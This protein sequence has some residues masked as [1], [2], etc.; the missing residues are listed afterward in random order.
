ML[1]EEPVI[2]RITLHTTLGKSYGPFGG[3]SQYIYGDTVGLSNNASKY[4]VSASGKVL[5]YIA[6]SSGAAV[7]SLTFYFA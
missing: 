1:W 7:D 2:I 5:R 4:D 6:G 3:S